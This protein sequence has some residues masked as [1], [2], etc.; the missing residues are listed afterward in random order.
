MGLLLV[1]AGIGILI[2]TLIAALTPDV[3]GWRGACRTMGCETPCDRREIR[4]LDRPASDEYNGTR[5]SRCLEPNSMYTAILIRS[6]FS[7]WGSLPSFF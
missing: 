4:G 1:A 3:R 2:T 6:A 7:R 5:I